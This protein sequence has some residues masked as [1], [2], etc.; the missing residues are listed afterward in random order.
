MSPRLGRLSRDNAYER[1][2]VALSPDPTS[3]EW[4][5]ER[6]KARFYGQFV[7]ACGHPILWLHPIYCRD[8]GRCL[9]IGTVCLRTH[10]KTASNAG[11]TQLALTLDRPVAGRSAHGSNRRGCRGGSRPNNPQSTQT[12]LG[13]EC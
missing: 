4:R 1:L 10:F 11:A 6:V 13:F 2:L 8:T 5:G 3:W 7:C 9:L 12:R